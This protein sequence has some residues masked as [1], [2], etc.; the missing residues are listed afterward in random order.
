[1]LKHPGLT[2]GGGRGGMINGGRFKNIEIFVFCH[3]SL[4]QPLWDLI[5]FYFL[6]NIYIISLSKNFFSTPIVVWDNF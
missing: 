5:F 1:L 6:H 2:C 4:A 3:H